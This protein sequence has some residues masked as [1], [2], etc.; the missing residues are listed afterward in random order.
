MARPLRIEF[1]GALY[2]VT[3]RG[4]RRRPIFENDSDRRLW[5]DILELVCV[6]SDFIVYAYCQMGNHY[7]LLLETPAGN[8]SQGMRRLNSRYTQAFNRRHDYVGHVF[9][10]RYKAILVDKESYLL[11]VARYIVLNPV[12]AGIVERPEEWKWGSYSATIS[13]SASNSWL[14]TNWLLSRFAGDSKVAAHRY[15]DFVLAGI[16]RESP[17]KQVQHQV[18]LG[19]VSFVEQQRQQLGDIDLTALVKCQKRLAIPSLAECKSAHT[20]RDSAM[21]AAYM[22]TGYTMREIASYFNVSIQAVSRAVNRLR[23]MS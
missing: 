9:Q 23:A 1:P 13:S 4:D 8:L 14:S 12:R 15:R 22:T 20:D 16:G 11:E 17:M 2:H 10:G 18:I 7:H 6:Q 21:A 5:L 19:D 3:S